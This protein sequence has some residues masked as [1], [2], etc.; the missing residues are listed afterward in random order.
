M[1]LFWDLLHRIPSYKK[2]SLKVIHL[3]AIAVMVWF[4]VTKPIT[5]YFLLGALLGFNTNKVEK[6]LKAIKPSIIS[7]IT[8]ASL[9]LISYLV[10]IN[11]EFGSQGWLHSFSSKE[12]VLPIILL[13]ILSLLL[14]NDNLFCKLLE[15][16]VLTSS[17]NI[18]YTLYLLHPYSYRVCRHLIEK[19]NI[20]N[21]ILSFIIFIIITTFLTLT[22]SFIVSKFFE[23]PIYKRYSK[24][25]VYTS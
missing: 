11:T 21:G 4:V 5:I 14:S 25:E 20:Q 16:K 8:C 17:G 9:F 1:V 22:A 15:N 12:F 24:K 13:V 23:M 19:I 10:A 7:L 6:S 18:S 2:E 3:L